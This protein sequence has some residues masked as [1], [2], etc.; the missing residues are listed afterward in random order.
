[1]KQKLLSI[2]VT[3]LLFANAGYA[4]Q[5][6][7]EG[8]IK[9][10]VT[11]NID[12]SVNLVANI[13]ANSGNKIA[14][15]KENKYL[16]DNVQSFVNELLA[17]LNVD[18]EAIFKVKGNKVIAYAGNNGGVGT[19]YDGDKGVVY[20]CYNYAKVAIKYT[21]EEFL[22]QIIEKPRVS[23][24]YQIL[25]DSVQNIYGYSCYKTITAV[26]YDGVVINITEQW[27]SQEIML[28]QYFYDVNPA[29]TS[30][31][32]GFSTI[33][34]ADMYK[35]EIGKDNKIS[36]AE[37][38]GKFVCTFLTE[39]N[40]SEVKDKEFIIPKKYVILTPTTE[41]YAK[42]RKLLN[43]NAKKKKTYTVGSK[44]PETFWDF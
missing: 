29:I 15:A 14:D 24:D 13:K 16:K 17:S 28:P 37:S 41:G 43:D 5:K 21:T 38:N 7:F 33:S 34:K 35:F 18:Y 9:A 3:C 36:N 1:M 39:V 20:I 32:K 30:I 40:T 6:T 2:I 19:M 25:K 23:Y 12:N 8:T 10:A 27:M 4:Q 22:K 31:G 42:L 26:K 44:I 11:M